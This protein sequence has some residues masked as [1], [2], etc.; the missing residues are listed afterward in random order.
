MPKQLSS[1]NYLLQ[2]KLNGIPTVIFALNFFDD[3]LS[4]DFTAGFLSII[5]RNSFPEQLDECFWKYKL[6]SVWKKTPF[7][8]ITKTLK[9]QAS[10]FIIDF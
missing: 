8:L 2:N 7:R 9:K 10:I 6:L 5:F 1:G 3:F 4:S